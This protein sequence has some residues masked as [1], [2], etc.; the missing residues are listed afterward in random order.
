M[1]I[2][3]T[4]MRSLIYVDCVREEYRHKLK[5]WLQYHH[6]SESISQFQPYVTKYAFYAALPVPEKG[7]QFGAYRMQL[8][9]HYWLVNPLSQD[10]AVHAFSEYFP[11]EVLKWQGTIP[12]DDDEAEFFAG[13]DARST[14]GNNGMPPFIFAFLPISWEEDLKGCGR[15]IEDG[16]NYRWQFML[17]YPDGVSCE[18][19]DAWF[20][21]EF[22]KVFETADTVTRILTSRVKQ[23]IN[24][25]SFQRVVEIWFEGPEE[26]R[27]TI[28]EAMKTV[29]KPAWAKCDVF[30]Y[31]K[32][33]FEIAS[34]FL[35]DTP[36]SDN[37][38]QYR[39]FISMR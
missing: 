37:F 28:D 38:T 31:L 8:T 23:E 11:K 29:A 35:T 20:R 30:P 9:E 17:K 6:I 12:D 14:G 34:L 32:P 3:F 7:D 15:T 2:E 25:C 21:E 16:P 10:L 26:W 22:L 4:P 36:D 13:D 24:H 19:G 39:G 18:E 33:K 5:H 1:G 27:D